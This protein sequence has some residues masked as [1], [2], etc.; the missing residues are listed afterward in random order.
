MPAEI[1]P[2]YYTGSVE[3]YNWTA[4]G[5]FDFTT[6][7]KDLDVPVLVLYGKG[8][9]FGMSMADAVVSSLSRAEVKFV[10]LEK[11][12]HYWRECPGVFFSQVRAFL[13]LPY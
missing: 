12:G 13:D 6:D 3:Q 11:C 2:L 7:T 10:L 8:D 9:P 5:D 4:L 1:Q